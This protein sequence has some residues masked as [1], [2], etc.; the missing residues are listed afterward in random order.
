MAYKVPTLDGMLS[1]VVALFK[2]LLP[3]RNIGS[4]FSVHWRLAKVIAGA[5]TD[6]H[7]NLDVSMKDAM[8]D[9]ARGLGLDRWIGIVAPGGTTQRKGATPS[10]RS[11]A[12]RVRGTLAAAV[13]SG[14]TL[15]HRPT[16]LR[17]MI[18]ESTAIPAGLSVDVDI[19]ALDKGSRTRLEAGEILE[20]EAS[21][22]G[23]QNKVELQKALSD[24]GTDA[25]LDGAARNRLLLAFGTPAA[26]GNQTDYVG[27]VLAQLG[28]ATGFCY[29]NRAGLGTVDV[30]AFHQGSGSARFLTP[31]ER[32]T[33]LAALELLA[34]SGVAGTNSSNA[35][36]V[37]TAVGGDTDAANLAN[38]EMTITPDGAP[39]NAF[40]WDDTA[41]PTVLLWTAATRTLQFAAPRPASM[42][43][44]NRIALRGVASSQDGTPLVIEALGVGA[45]TVI[46]RTAPTNAPAA[47]DIVYAQGPLSILVRDAILAHIN[48]DILYAGASAALPASTLDST[49]NFEVLVDGI[50]SANPLGAYGTWRGGLLKGTLQTIAMYTRGVRNQ[51]VIA[52]VADLEAVDYAFPLDDQIGTLTPGYVLIRRG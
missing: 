14:W 22:A 36:R 46:L 40:D 2:A 16:G 3:N 37:L 7:A 4:R 47:T 34:P 43:A 24:D 11:D 32:T 10:R 18:N 5:V 12:G 35:L 52:P 42:A 48:G 30:V 15:T 17:F 25:E 26:G 45:D 38:V 8:P 28:I 50:G 21:H 31:A 51:A 13:T 41:P 33:L 9:T 29:P 6:L 27:W 1:F 20:F 44:G 23:I 39:Q 49:D 19:V